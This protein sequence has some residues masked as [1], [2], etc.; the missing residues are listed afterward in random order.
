MTGANTRPGPLAPA[1][2]WRPL[3]AALA[4]IVLLTGGWSLAATPFPDRVGVRPDHPIGLG[5]GAAH[6]DPGATFTPSGPGWQLTRTAADPV[7]GYLLSRP[8]VELRVSYVPF[9]GEAYGEH[10]AEDLWPGLVRVARL[11][12]GELG[13]PRPISARSG[14]EGRTGPLSQDERT[15]SMTAFAHPDRTFALAFTLLGVPAADPADRAAAHRTVRSVRF[16]GG[17]TAT[18]PDKVPVLGPVTG[19]GAGDA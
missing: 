6:G 17:G 19:P 2:S 16:P 14:A 15:G 13:E 10:T 7:R 4:V 11:S 18:A 3:L 8:G 1:A 9:A 5:S 12:D